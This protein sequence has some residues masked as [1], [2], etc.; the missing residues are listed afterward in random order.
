MSFS[1]TNNN[2]RGTTSLEFYFNI[3][4]TTPSMTGAT[5]ASVQLP[6]LWD[7]VAKMDDGSWTGGAVT[8]LEDSWDT[9]EVPA[10]NT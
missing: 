4:A 9:T 7:R 1:S 3:P 8:L 2:V 5:Y 6:Y 10:V